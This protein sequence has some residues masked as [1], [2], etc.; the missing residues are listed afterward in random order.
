[1]SLA[2]TKKSVGLHTSFEVAGAMARIRRGGL[3]ARG[4]RRAALLS[5][6]TSAYANNSRNGS[7][8][9]ANG[10]DRS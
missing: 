1:M 3:S 9:G 8:R 10:T 7:N 4:G 5:V 6:L 2:N